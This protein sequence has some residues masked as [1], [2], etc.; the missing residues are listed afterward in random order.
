M[1]IENTTWVGE[2][3]EEAGYYHKRLR[4]PSFTGYV[5]YYI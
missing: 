3:D 2:R 1:T 5:Y 4:E